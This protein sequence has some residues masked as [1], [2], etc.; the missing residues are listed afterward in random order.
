MEKILKLSKE[1]KKFKFCSP[2]DDPDE[3]TSVI[4][5]FKHL[6]K[7]FINCAKKIENPEIKQMLS[8]IDCNIE[9]IYE[10]YDLNGDLNCIIDNIEEG[11]NQKKPKLLPEDIQILKKL[12]CNTLKDE[13]AYDLPKICTSLGL[14]PGKKEEAFGS[15][16]VYVST[17]LSSLNPLEIF[18]LAEKINERYQSEELADLVIKISEK[19]G[20][21]LTT[22]FEEIK[23]MIISEV[24]KAEFLIWIA[25]AWITDRE[26]ANTLYTKVKQGVDIQLIINDDEINRKLEKKGTKFEDHFKVYRI[27]KLTLMHNKFCVIDL[28]KVLHGSYNWTTKAQFNKETITLIEN[29]EV[30]EKFAKE[31]IKIKSCRNNSL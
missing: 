31:F 16:N 11:F 12:I 27:P 19:D 13:K 14:E 25:V 9:S 29:R 21:N 5:G 7:K 17:R 15:K 1:I 10:V 6:A 20:L 30:A 23:K 2:S 22:T 28:K 18:T 8:K 4:Y 3:Q 26:I 24:N